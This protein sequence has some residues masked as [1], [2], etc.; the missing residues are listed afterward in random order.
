[1]WVA[2]D[3]DDRARR[4]HRLPARLTVARDRHRRRGRVPDARR[5][6]RRRRDAAWAAPWRRMVVDRFRAEGDR[7]VV[8]SSLDEM[9]TAHGLYERLGFVRA[10]ERDWRPQPARLPH[11]LPPGALVTARA[12]PSATVT[13]TVG[14]TDTALA[15]GSGSLEVLGTPR[16]LAWCEAATCAALEPDPGRRVDQRRHPHRARAH[17]RQPRRAGRR[18]DRLDDV[19]RR[20]AAP[21]HASPRATSPRTVAP[22]RWSPRARSPGWSSTPSS[23]SSRL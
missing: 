20:A 15:V 4:G 13:F 14:E 6:P 23:S 17:R 12:D 21:L 19:R 22:A 8:L 9:T 7:R 1:M 3:G 18:G 5:R 2:A 11:R 16:L 10:P